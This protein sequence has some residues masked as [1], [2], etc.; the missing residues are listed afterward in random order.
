MLTCVS[1]AVGLDKSL[2]MLRRIWFWKETATVGGFARLTS[3]GCFS[4][5]AHR[6]KQ[7]TFRR[8]CGRGRA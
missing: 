5:R 7:V 2:E 1:E 4:F 8:C 6:R 3:H